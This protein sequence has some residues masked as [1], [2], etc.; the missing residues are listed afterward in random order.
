MYCLA[1]DEAFNMKNTFCTAILFFITAGVFAA[2]DAEAP[3]ETIA[4]R[5]A[6]LQASRAIYKVEL[7]IATQKAALAELQKKNALGAASAPTSVPSTPAPRQ[8]RPAR[9][10]EM[11]A[12][13]VTSI[14]GVADKISAKLLIEGYEKTVKAGDSVPGGWIVEKLDAKSLTLSRNGQSVVVKP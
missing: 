3:G 4:E 2:P 13:S 7:D 11:P 12:P 14:S 1:S 5:L 10:T 6:R 9:E 8:P